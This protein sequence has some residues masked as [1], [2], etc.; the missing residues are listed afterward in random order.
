MVAVA[1]MP[2][3]TPIKVPSNTPIKQKNRFSMDEAVLKPRRRLLN[4]SMRRPQN[5]S[6][7]PKRWNG[8]PRP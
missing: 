5:L 3:K 4:S 6:Q 8:R 1:P 2:G 7:G